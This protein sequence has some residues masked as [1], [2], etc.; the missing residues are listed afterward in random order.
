MA[1]TV[2]TTTLNPAATNIAEELKTRLAGRALSCDSGSSVGIPLCDPL[3]RRLRGRA[4]VQK[5]LGDRVR[6]YARAACGRWIG[7]DP[8]SSSYRSRASSLR[9]AKGLVGRR[10]EESEIRSEVAGPAGLPS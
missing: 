3:K 10:L 9:C 6:S 8:S 2:R 5:A 4:P 1:R 7:S